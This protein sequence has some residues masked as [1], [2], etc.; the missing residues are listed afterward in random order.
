MKSTDKENVLSKFF[1]KKAKVPGAS[2]NSVYSFE[3]NNSGVTVDYESDSDAHTLRKKSSNG[4]FK[5][6]PKPS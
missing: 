6:S 1:K 5:R 2:S 4:I 3:S